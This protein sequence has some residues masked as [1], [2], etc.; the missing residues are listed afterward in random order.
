MA[1]SP[2]VSAAIV[3]PDGRLWSGAAGRA[4][5]EPARRMTTQT[6]LP[7]ASIT[8]LA[9][10]ALALRLVEHGRLGL[11]SQGDDELWGHGGEM[12]GGTSEL[13][14]LPARDVTIAI[15]WNDDLFGREGSTV[16]ALLRIAIP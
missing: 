2:G 10:A 15:A 12:V 11:D 13:W 7:F 8:K 1:E 9:T 14:H 6:S 16:P 3:F 5:L 4:V